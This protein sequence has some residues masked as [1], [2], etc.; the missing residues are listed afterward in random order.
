MT[1]SSVI[2]MRGLVV[3]M[4]CIVAAEVMHHK[5]SDAVSQGA[6]SAVVEWFATRHA[7]STPQCK[8]CGNQ[9]DEITGP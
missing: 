9:W 7:I 1:G 6:C 4:R 2:V 3:L 8:S 5:V